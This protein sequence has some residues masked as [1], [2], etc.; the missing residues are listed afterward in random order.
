M[1]HEFHLPNVTKQ[2]QQPTFLH[3]MTRKYRSTCDSDAESSNRPSHRLIKANFVYALDRR[4]IDLNGAFTRFISFGKDTIEEYASPSPSVSSS[5]GLLKNP[6]CRSFDRWSTENLQNWM[7]SLCCPISVCLWF[8][9]RHRC[10]RETSK[11]VNFWSAFGC[12]EIYISSFT[13]IRRTCVVEVGS[14]V[15][16]GSVACKI[17]KDLERSREN[18]RW[19]A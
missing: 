16:V 6:W 4:C 17:S 1:N 8:H 10:F 15:R 5:S 12:W 18:R 11:Y 14:S 13:L 3:A 2:L 19:K 7:R 9:R